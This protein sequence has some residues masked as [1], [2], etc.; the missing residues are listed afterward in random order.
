MVPRVLCSMTMCSWSKLNC[1]CRGRHKVSSITGV[2]RVLNL[3]CLSDNAANMVVQ[4]YIIIRFRRNS[5]SGGAGEVGGG[6]VINPSW[7][8]IKT[9]R[10]HTG[11]TQ[12]SISHSHSPLPAVSCV[13]PP[14][15]PPCFFFLLPL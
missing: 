3:Q 4:Y 2:A 8:I 9:F 15:P 5:G 1:T 13:P 10:G 12:V 7:L 14:P 6:G 11:A